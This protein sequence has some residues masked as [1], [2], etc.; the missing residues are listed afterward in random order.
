MRGLKNRKK[1]RTFCDE[2][3]PPKV[4]KKTR[5]LRETLFFLLRRGCGVGCVGGLSKKTPTRLV[6]RQEVRIFALLFG[7]KHHLFIF[8]H[9]KVGRFKL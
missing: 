7:K 6:M 9:K 4:G 1:D 2:S 8:K 3:Y 5:F